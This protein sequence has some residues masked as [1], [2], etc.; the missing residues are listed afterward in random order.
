MKSKERTNSY[1]PSYF[2]VK[3]RDFPPS[4]YL[5]YNEFGPT[6]RI[7]YREAILKRYQD[8]DT[9][10]ESNFFRQFELDQNLSL[11]TQAQMHKF[12][13][14]VE[15]ARSKLSLLEYSV[16]TLRYGLDDKIAVT[17]KRTAMEIG[18]MTERQVAVVERTALKKVKPFFIQNNEM[19]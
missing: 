10:E 12:K 5:V 7:N 8:L 13:D 6:P 18:K 19:A 15:Q 4:G 14:A 2:L 11:E 9:S 16:L 3:G 17:Q 1:N